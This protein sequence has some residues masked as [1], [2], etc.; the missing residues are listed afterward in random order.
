[1]IKIRKLKNIEYGIKKVNKLYL[2]FGFKITRIHA[3]SEFEPIQ[4]EMDD[5]VISLTFSSKKEHVP[6]IKN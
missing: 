3:D 2:Q 1:M 4:A 6:E 5:L